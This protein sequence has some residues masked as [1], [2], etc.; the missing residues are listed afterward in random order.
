M[1]CEAINIDEPLL[2][3]FFNNSDNSL[4]D[5]GSN[6]LAGSSNKY[7]LAFLA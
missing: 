7:T 1:S 6:P 2:A 4:L 5:K 3:S